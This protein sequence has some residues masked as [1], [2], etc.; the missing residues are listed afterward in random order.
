MTESKLLP[1]FVAAPLAGAFLVAL[2]GRQLRRFPQMMGLLVPS[3]LFVLSL[4]LLG[5]I[6]RHGPLVHFLG[7]WK[8]PVGIPMVSDGLTVFM[9]V[10]VYGVASCIALFSTSYIQKYTAPWMFYTLFLLILAGMSGVLMTGDLFDLFVYLE[11]T[12]LAAWKL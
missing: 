1:L 9:L 5:T 6:V 11:I 8:P 4:V 10:T 3:G 2:L 7:G 12:S